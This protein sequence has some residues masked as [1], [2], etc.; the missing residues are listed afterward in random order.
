MTSKRILSA[1]AGLLAGAL[2]LSGCTGDGNG[3]EP[4]ADGEL[5]KITVAT[6]PSAQ[7]APL[8]LGIEDGIF[9][10]HGLEVEVVHQTDIGAILAGVASNQYQFGFATAVH[11]INSNLN[12]IPIR[13]VATVDGRQ[14]PDEGPDDGNSLVAGPDSGISSAA[15]LG[16]KTLAVVGLASLNTFTAS[17]LAAQAG[18]DPSTIDLVQLP[19]GQMAAALAGGEVDA[20]VIQAPFIA[21]A[22][23]GGSTVIGKPNVE[24]FPDMAI[25]FYN[26]TQSYIDQSPEV[27]QAFSDA[28]IAS[29]EHA[30]ANVEKARATLVTQLDLTEEAAQAAK[31]NVGSDPRVNLDGLT[32]AQELLIAYNDQTRELDVETLV[33][34]GALQAD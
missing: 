17:E 20:A 3:T 4:G 26:T 11:V 8:Y 32:R 6:N 14:N 9:A 28:I 7:M 29:Q 16:G 21:D 31:W 33:W 18:V 15:D 5:T 19:F 27:V 25:G 10:E 22:I 30:T 1:A 34:P 24:V 12:D 2:L 23:A 13:A